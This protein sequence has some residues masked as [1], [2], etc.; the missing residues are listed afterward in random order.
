MTRVLVGFDGSP[1]SVT[2]LGHAL[3]TF[4]DAEIHVVTVVDPTA[5]LYAVDGSAPAYDAGW[6][7]AAGERAEELLESAEEEA[8][9]VGA[10]ITTDWVQG[11]PSRALIEYAEDH[12]VDHIVVG[13]Q[14]RT[15]LSRLLLGSV[16]ETVVR[17]S[18]VPVTVAR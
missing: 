14:G 1:S 3:D 18:P 9:A 16:A 5:G 13:S 10:T 6:H 11:R 17:R 7:E 2:A 4:D 8:A 12:D 15:G